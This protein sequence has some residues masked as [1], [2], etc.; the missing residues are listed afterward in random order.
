MR[1]AAEFAAGHIP[2]AINIPGGDTAGLAAPPPKDKFIVVYCHG[3]MKAPSA[4][5]KMLADG[6]RHVLAWGGI[7]NWP[8]ERGTSPR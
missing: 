6:Y 3:G 2:T 5:E 4:R 7:M 8:Y 1:S